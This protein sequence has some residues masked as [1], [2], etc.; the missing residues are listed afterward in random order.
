MRAAVIHADLPGR[1]PA[2]A[3][4]FA[5]HHDVHVLVAFPGTAKC[6]ADQGA[7]VQGG[8]GG[9]MDLALTQRQVFG[10]DTFPGRHILLRTGAVFL[11]GRQALN[12]MV[13]IVESILNP[14]FGS[15]HLRF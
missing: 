8:Q 14:G 4:S 2:A 1:T 12:F 11:P 15:L 6:G 9:S 13:G 5:A 10:K 3:G 7:I